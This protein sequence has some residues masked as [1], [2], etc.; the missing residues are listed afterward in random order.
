MTPLFSVVIPTYRRPGL[1]QAALASVAAQ[2]FTD[3]EVIVVDDDSDHGH[4]KGGAGARNAG[5]AQAQGEWVAFLD[6]DDRWMPEKL[7][8]VAATIAPGVTFVHHG[9]EYQGK[10]R[11]PSARVIGTTSVATVKRD[12]LM[13]IGGFDETLCRYQDS[14]L[15]RR[16]GLADD[17]WVVLPPP[18]SAAAVNV[19]LMRY[20][21]G[22]Y[23]RI[24]DGK[25]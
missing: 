9:W 15:Y 8:L 14:D 19:A 22:D 17:K 6:D 3:Y 21:H 1:L 5:I 24:S 4:A 20:G 16:L 7:E 2:T 11:L 10:V 25:A 18:P 12:T 13:A 23:P